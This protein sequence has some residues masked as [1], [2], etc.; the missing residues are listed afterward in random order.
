MIEIRKAKI[1]ELDK[2]YEIGTQEHSKPYLGTKTMD[3]YKREFVDKSTTY[4]SI[5]NISNN[6]LGYMI[7]FQDQRKNSIQLK[8]I[9]ISKESFGI[10]QKALT[11]LEQFC[12]DTMSI[13][14]IYLDV[15]DDNYKAIHIYE[16][17]D[18]QLINT[19]IHDNRKILFYEKLL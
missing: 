16:K 2:L 4:L 9:L 19:Q 7:L 10:G 11:K 13:K 3:D 5:V 6:I 14:R 17:L 1:E 8:R 12:I 15:Y 18:Y